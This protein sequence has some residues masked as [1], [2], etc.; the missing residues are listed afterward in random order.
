MLCGVKFSKDEFIKQTPDPLYGKCNYNPKTGVKVTEF[1]ETKIHIDESRAYK[2]DIELITPYYT[3]DK[4]EVVVGYNLLKIS[5]KQAIYRIDP[6][7]FTL[8]DEQINELI[9]ILSVVRPV[10]KDEIKVYLI[11]YIS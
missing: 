1:I 3:D 10:S 11:G 9:D 7:T 5:Y 6:T 4:D 2:K 8:T